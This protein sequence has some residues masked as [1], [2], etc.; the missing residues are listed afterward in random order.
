MQHLIADPAG[1]NEEVFFRSAGWNMHQLAYIDSE[2]FHTPSNSSR[3]SSPVSE[4]PSNVSTIRANH[5]VKMHPP[6]QLET[7]PNHD[8]DR[9][10]VNP[11]EYPDNVK[12]SI[13]KEL[14]EFVT[15]AEKARAKVLQSTSSIGHT[16]N[17]SQSK[18]KIP[19]GDILITT[20][21][22]GSAI[23]SKLRNVSAT[24][25]T[26]PKLSNGETGG[27]LLD[28]GEGTLGQLRRRFGY[29]G[30]KSVYEQLKMIFISHMHADHH[31]GLQAVLEDRFKV[32]L[33]SF[34]LH[35]LSN[36]LYQVVCRKD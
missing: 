7:L 27:I 33:N 34:S 32:S 13:L 36:V 29:D 15:A 26:I 35:P 22:T 23:P 28:C 30:L 5:Q 21:G 4:L 17:S 20:L 31:L 6:G 14:P 9:P 18:K 25:L 1:G 12:N 16:P 2:I 8:K 24:L 10:L 11:R 3:P 19:G